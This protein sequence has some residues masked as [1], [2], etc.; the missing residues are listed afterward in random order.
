MNIYLAR[1]VESEYNEKNLLNSDPSVYVGLTKKGVRQAEQLASNLLNRQANF[2]LIYTSELPRTQLTAEII[3]RH[4]NKQIIVDPLINENK[5]GY[6]GKL[7]N[8]WKTA[9]NNSNDPWNEAFNDGESMSAAFSRS[10]QFFDKLKQQ[11]YES[12]LVITH[13][14]HVQALTGLA[15][16]KTGKDAMDAPT[17]QGQFTTLH[18]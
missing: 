14:F 16:N 18:V 1:H 2:E 13:G 17:P 8:E 11:P 7:F 9:L 6:E 4:H 12:V 3:N 10:K 5:T 15:N